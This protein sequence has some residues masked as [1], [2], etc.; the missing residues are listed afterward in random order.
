[1]SKQILAT[2]ASFP[3]NNRS[4]RGNKKNCAATRVR[5]YNEAILPNRRQF[6]P[7]ACLAHNVRKARNALMPQLLRNDAVKRP[8]RPSLVLSNFRISFTQLEHVRAVSDEDRGNFGSD[9]WYSGRMRAARSRLKTLIHLETLNARVAPAAAA[10][11][12]SIGP[13][14]NAKPKYTNSCVK[15][16]EELPPLY[17]S[18]MQLPSIA[19]WLA[20]QPPSRCTTAKQAREL[21]LSNAPYSAQYARQHAHKTGL[22]PK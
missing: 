16:S 6:Q 8:A 10:S 3:G 7:K 9:C 21:V 22:R 5:P 20:M 18:T 2:Q 4:I 11:P 14:T 12:P 1:M 13:M 17:A 15:A 19:A